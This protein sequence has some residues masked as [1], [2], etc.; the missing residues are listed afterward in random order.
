MANC[1]PEREQRNSQWLLG[2]FCRRARRPL[3]WS[4]RRGQTP[5]RSWIRT[6][7]VFSLP[8]TAEL[9]C[10]CS[11]W[12]WKWVKIRVK[13]RRSKDVYKHLYNNLFRMITIMLSL[14]LLRKRT[15]H[16]ARFDM[17]TLCIACGDDSWPRKKKMIISVSRCR[18]GIEYNY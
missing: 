4:T 14:L 8:K 2:S 10:T 16:S 12:C 7:K 13:E 15:L 11:G 1:W 5:C 17:N 6:K 9:E 3:R 18:T